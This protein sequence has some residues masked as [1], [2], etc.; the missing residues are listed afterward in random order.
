MGLF[1]PNYKNHTDEALMQLMAE[2]KKAAL[3]ELYKRYS[4]KM[5]FFF[6]RMFNRDSDKAEDFLHDL[7]LKLIEKPHLFNKEMR[8]SSWLY[9]ISGNMCRNEYRRLSIRNEI[10]TEAELDHFHYEDEL[11]SASI[12]NIEFQA[13]VVRALDEMEPEYKMTFLLRFQEYLPVSEISLI[14][15]CP[16]GTVKSRIFYTIKK[17]SAKLMIYNPNI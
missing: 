4:K 9:S 11:A 2:G 16:E 7:F 14:M 10:K 8:F 17:L 6:Y 3:D 1:S 5:H 12:D 13:A 15:Q